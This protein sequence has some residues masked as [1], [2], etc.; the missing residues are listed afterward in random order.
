MC[1]K[2]GLTVVLDAPR[3]TKNN[4]PQQPKQCNNRFYQQNHAPGHGRIATDVGCECKLE[5]NMIVCTKIGLTVVSDAPRG[6]K[7]TSPAAEAM[8]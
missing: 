4:L 2:I 5:N 6:I 1:T 8:H 3:E 7:T